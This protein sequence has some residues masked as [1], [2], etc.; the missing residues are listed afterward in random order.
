MK[1]ILYYYFVL[2]LSFPRKL[3]KRYAFLRCEEEREQFLYHLLSL[4]A[5]DYFCFTSVF[6][7][8]SKSGELTVKWRVAQMTN[9]VRAFIFKMRQTLWQFPA[10]PHLYSGMKVIPQ[11]PEV[12]LEDLPHLSAPVG[13]VS[14]KK[15]PN[16]RLS[17][18]PEPASIP[19]S[20]MNCP[21]THCEISRGLTVSELVFCLSPSCFLTCWSRSN[22]L[23]SASQE[24]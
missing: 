7:T 11:Q 18:L 4:N 24:S 14:P 5:V 21:R 23:R 6:T 15:L 12:L 2:V 3:Y 16:L 10:H 1:N 13:S 20:A 9:G 22:I 19:D 8:I 17:L